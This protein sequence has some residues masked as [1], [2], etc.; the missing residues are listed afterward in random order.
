MPT[1]EK[2]KLWCER[3]VPKVPA[4]RRYA[5]SHD[6]GEIFLVMEGVPGVPLSFIWEKL[7]LWESYYCHTWDDFRHNEKRWMSMAWLFFW[8]SRRKRRISLLILQP[9][10]RPE[11]QSLSWVLSVRIVPW[12]IG[13]ITQTASWMFRKISWRFLQGHHPT[14]THEDIPQKNIMVVENIVHQNG[15]SG[16][17]F[18]VDVVLI[19]WENSCLNSRFREFCCAS[20]PL[21]FIGTKSGLVESMTLFERSVPRWP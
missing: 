19:D 9:T 2:V 10:W 1:S 18:D 13:I 6:D 21:H 3:N 14:F 17:S 8:K 11:K 12:S 7:A 16:R 15:E 4:P 5:T 20:Y